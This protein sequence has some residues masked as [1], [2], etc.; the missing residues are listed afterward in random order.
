LFAGR[1]FLQKHVY[2]IDNI[3]NRTVAELGLVGH[4]ALITVPP[5]MLTLLAFQARPVSAQSL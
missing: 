1:R 5:R 4:Q 3:A 2:E